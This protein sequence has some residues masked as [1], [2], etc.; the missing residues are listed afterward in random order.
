M[1]RPSVGSYV[2]GFV[3]P[4]FRPSVGPSVSPLGRLYRFGMNTKSFRDPMLLLLLV[5]SR[6]FLFVFLFLWMSPSVI[7]I[8]VF[9]F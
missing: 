7:R 9:F 3:R 2:C 4:W 8:K 6:L 5:F 1:V